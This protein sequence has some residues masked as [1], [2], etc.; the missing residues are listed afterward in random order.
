MTEINFVK[1]SEENLRKTNNQIRCVLKKVDIDHVSALGMI[2]AIT[3]VM[4]IF[5]HKKELIQE[6]QKFYNEILTESDN[7]LTLF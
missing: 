2:H 7:C 3:K 6:F 1:Y 4:H 5:I